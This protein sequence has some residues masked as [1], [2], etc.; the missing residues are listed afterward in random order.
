[1]P[2]FGV[3][4]KEKLKTCDPAIQAVLEEAIKLVDFSVIYGHRNQAEQDKAFAEK[5]SKLPWPQSKHN[6]LPSKAVD[7]APYPI[8]WS[9]HK[10]F[11]YFAGIC[12]GIAHAKGIKLRWGG[13]WDMDGNLKEETF[14]D[15]PHLELA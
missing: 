10:R 12:V 3:T 14:I 15:M 7:I 11:A 1:M 9:D 4:S 2:E 13:D 8:D 6:S 5:K